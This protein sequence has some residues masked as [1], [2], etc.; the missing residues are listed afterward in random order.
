ME[1]KTLNTNKITGHNAE[2]LFVKLVETLNQID[3]IVK[4]TTYNEGGE[5]KPLYA[6]TGNITALSPEAYSKMMKMGICDRRRL[7]HYLNRLQSNKSVF[8]MNKLMRFIH[9]TG[10][11]ENLVKICIPKHEKIQSMR[12]KMIEAKAIYEQYLMDYKTEKGDFYKSI[13]K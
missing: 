3:K 10:L 13:L 8:H 1:T 11:S 12:K 4:T 7:K 5:V 6:V 9:R 2:E